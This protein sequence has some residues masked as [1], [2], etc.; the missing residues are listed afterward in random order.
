MKYKETFYSRHTVLNMYY[1]FDVLKTARLVATSV[2]QDQNVVSD[3]YLHR[4]L[5]S[6]CQ[7]TKGK[8]GRL[9]RKIS[10]IGLS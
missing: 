5:K 9:L 3:R 2:H 1:T 10:H 4:L 6:V 8:Y 7:S